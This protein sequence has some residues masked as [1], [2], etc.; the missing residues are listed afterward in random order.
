MTIEWPFKR[1]KPVRCGG[2]RRHMRPEAAYEELIELSRRGARLASCLELLAWDEL[3]Y[4]PPAGVTHRA[5][6]L[7]LLT[8]L[9]HACVTDPRNGELIGELERSDLALD[10]F[11]PEAVNIREIRRTV[12]RQRRRPRRLVEELARI[13]C[14]AQC[15]W[16]TARR[17]CNFAHFCPWLEKIVALKKE[18]A[19]ALGYEANRY[20]A[21]LEEYEP[22]SRCADIARMFD[23][24][25][26]ELISL[27]NALVEK[28]PRAE[29]LRDN[30]PVERQ[31]ILCQAVAAAVGF[32]F[33][34]GRLDT[35]VHPFTS[36]IGPGDCRLTIRYNPDCFCDALL[37]TLHE[38]GHGLYDQGLDAEHYGTPLSEVPSLG[39]HESQARLWE[40][41]VGRS[42]AFWDHFLPQARALFPGTLDGMVVDD[43]YLAVNRVE[44]SSIRVTA[45]EVTY[46]LHIMVRFE[47]ERA[48]LAGD[49]QVE[50]VPAAWNEAY[51]QYLGVTPADDAVGCLQD[52]HWASG[53]IGYFPT[54]TLGNLFA[55]QLFA[56][57]EADLGG[58]CH[59]FAR[60]RYDGLLA[61][62]R[63]KI[64]RQGSRY[65]SAQLIE[66]VTGTPPSHQP[67]V[68]ALR[69]KYGE[70]YD[71]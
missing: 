18:E 58:L 21:L 62:L 15:E 17:E 22:H 49:L 67:F 26:P 71:V 33:Q 3:T 14:R 2:N 30:F 27:I 47:L 53:Q 68:D 63:Q 60:G 55:A 32:D 59:A 20:D 5:N 8:G 66:R 44:P 69:R 9:Y 54:Y 41:F 37:T 1:A 13:T 29:A 43:V 64:H 42:R 10:P 50:D 56:Q 48:L 39:L 35:A 16:A 28:V 52:G 12:N 19:E 51:R 36:F 23:A 4:L 25:R 45:D 6:Q 7:A 70:L 31:Q 57:A 34:G 46:N 65:S 11:S 38:V 40:N 61:W 24:I